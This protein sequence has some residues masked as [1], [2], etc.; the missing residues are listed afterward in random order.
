VDDTAR[1]TY[2]ELREKVDRLAISFMEL[3]VLPDA[4]T[5]KAVAPLVQRPGRRGEDVCSPLEIER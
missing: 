5:K 3:R 4:Q 2:K 1:F